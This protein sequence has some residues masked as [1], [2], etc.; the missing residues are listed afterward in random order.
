MVS[1]YSNV[2]I[3]RQ[4]EAGQT[5]FRVA[6]PVETRAAG[7]AGTLGGYLI[8]I[9]AIAGGLLLYAQSLRVRIFLVALEAMMFRAF[10]YTL[11]R[12][13][14]FAFIPM[15]IVLAAFTRRN[16]LMVVYL[17]VSLNFLCIPFLPQMVKQRIATMAVAKMD[18]SGARYIEWEESPRE[19]ID[20]WKILLFERLP[21]SPLLG[22]GVG[23]LFVDGQ[24][25]LTLGEVGVIGLILFIWLLFRIFKNCIEIFNIDS[26][27]AS[28]FSSGLTLGFL[29]GFIGLLTQALSTNTFIIIRIMEPFWFMAAIISILPAIIP[30]TIKETE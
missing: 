16:K 24:I 21:K 4:L 30:P 8:L 12:G 19:R 10:L 5:F 14:Y 7:E 15:V 3:Q 29:A 13:S 25:F 28:D 9:M 22:F 17:L 23:K 20:S 11:S 27:K 26:V 2:F 18:V 1:A 6:P